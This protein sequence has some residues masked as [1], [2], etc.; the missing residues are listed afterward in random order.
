MKRPTAQERTI[1]IFTGK[2]DCEDPNARDGYAPSH[3]Q[4]LRAVPKP[5]VRWVQQKGSLSIWHSDAGHL[6]ELDRGGNYNV[7]IAGRRIGSYPNIVDATEAAESSG[8]S[9][10]EKK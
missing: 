7:S 1:S 2:A 6:I 8:P 4:R 9:T 10:G 3:P 5:A